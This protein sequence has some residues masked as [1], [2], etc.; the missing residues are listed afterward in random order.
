VKKEIA[1]MWVQALRSGEYRQGRGRL[2]REDGAMCCLGVLCDLVPSEVGKWNRLA[3]EMAGDQNE[4]HLPKSARDWA[5]MCSQA[6]M[7][8]HIKVQLTKLNDDGAT[9]SEI[10]DIIEKHWEEL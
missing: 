3:F 6:G 7:V 1:D 10:A 9:F 2:K 4:A 8:N 5:G